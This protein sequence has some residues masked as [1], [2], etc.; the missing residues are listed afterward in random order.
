MA[1][2]VLGAAVLQGPSDL[3]SFIQVRSSGFA[4]P[5]FTPSFAWSARGVWNLPSPMSFAHPVAWSSSSF[6]SESLGSSWQ[7]DQD[8]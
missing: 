3:C 1:A 4:P 6:I 2:A 8:P 5:S 7:G